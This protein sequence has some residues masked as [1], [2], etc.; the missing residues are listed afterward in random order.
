MGLL[1][2]Y[3][4]SVVFQPWAYYIYFIQSAQPVESIWQAMGLINIW[5]IPLLFII[6]GMGVCFAIRRRNWKELLR[7]RAKRILLPLIFGSFFIVPIS[8]YLYQDFNDL[9][10]IYYP[11]G[12]HLWFLG[13][14]FFYVLILSPIFFAFKR[15]PDNVLFRCLKWV[16]KFPATLY[17]FTLPFILEAV[18]VAPPQGYASYANTPHGFWLGLLAF[19]TG[20]VIIS[21]GG[22]FWHAVERIKVIALS[23]AIPLYIVRLLAFQ[24]EGPFFLTVIESWSWLFAVFGFGSTYLNRPSSTLVYLSKAVYPVYILHMIFLNLSAYLILPKPLSINMVSYVMY[25]EPNSPGQR[26]GLITGDQISNPEALKFIDNSSAVLK[27]TRKDLNIDLELSLKAKE[28]S[29]IHLSPIPYFIPKY[30]NSNTSVFKG[31]FYYILVIILT[32]SGCLLTY[33]YFV[34]RIGWFRPL[35]GVKNI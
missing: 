12:G 11:N 1:I 16:L 27:V 7:D 26:A 30:E 32:F 20:F 4:I 6:S 34:K 2:I 25:V 33:E 28:Y 31:L 5:R 21:L 13:N 22:I 3:H 10:P 23:I 9:D 8:G 18:L 15:N 17:L 24:L 35:F 14:I 29:G 19:L